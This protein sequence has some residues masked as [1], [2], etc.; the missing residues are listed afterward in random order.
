ELRFTGVNA[1]QQTGVS[2][3][4]DFEGNA[5]IR[6]IQLPGFITPI[7][8]N[9]GIAAL[10]GE[11]AALN[12]QNLIRSFLPVNGNANVRFRGDDFNNNGDFAGRSFYVYFTNDLLGKNVPDFEV[13]PIGG[14]GGSVR[15]PRQGYAA[16]L[17]AKTIFYL[18]QPDGEIRRFDVNVSN[19]A[20]SPN[21]TGDP[22]D[23]SDFAV[24]TL[25]GIAP[26]GA[27]AHQLYN[28]NDEIGQAYFL[29]GFGNAG[30]DRPNDAADLFEVQRLTVNATGGT[31]RLSFN[32]N[33]VDV[34]FTAQVAQLESAIESLPGLTDVAV[35]RIDLGLNTGSFEIRFLQV[36]GQTAQN[37]IDVQQLGLDTSRLLGTARINTLQDGGEPVKRL[38]VNTFDLLS[39]DISATPG[40]SSGVY[41]P[42]QAFN[43]ATQEKTN[44]LALPPELRSIGFGQPASADQRNPFRTGIN[45]R[46]G[47][48]AGAP[49]L[50]DVGG[51]NLAI[52]GVAS[53][54]AF[55]ALVPGGSG[56]VSSTSFTTYTRTSA[57]SN[58]ILNSNEIA[59]IYDLTFDLNAQVVGNDGVADSVVARVNNGFI[60]LLTGARGFEVLVYRDSLTKIRSL[61]IV[62]S[63]DDDFITIDSTLSIAAGVP[64][65][66]RGGGGNDTALV[67]DIL[68]PSSN[69]INVQAAGASTNVVTGFLPNG[70]P[71]T[72]ADLDV[73]TLF[74]GS[75]NDLVTVVSTAP[76]SGLLRID[77]GVGA[78]QVRVGVGNLDTIAA[79]VAFIGGAG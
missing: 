43:L 14:G 40:G 1:T 33:S 16:P 75:G 8:G 41:V 26:F 22:F 71:L 64:I 9:V 27:T 55:E 4:L 73:A 66:I 60:E 15:T 24:L 70:A 58:Q 6:N 5:D 78:D 31:Y 39:T 28:N 20:L 63:G 54:I 72:L 50:I 32:G 61:S 51:G 42:D 57:L 19:I 56:L 12:L 17:A 7:D 35:R 48:D 21:F 44:V 59:G 25:A 65:S 79:P 62:G 36:V 67:A 47:G 69:A 37:P 45:A 52:A 53:L 46:L 13:N 11:Q 23:G 18:P 49:A 38:G 74:F 3:S 68:D 34:P 30:T 77:G 2:L 76:V 29:A 10:P